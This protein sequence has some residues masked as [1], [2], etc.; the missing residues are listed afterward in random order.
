MTEVTKP[1]VFLDVD[2][3][4]NCFET[5]EE[6]YVQD[7][8]FVPTA[9]RPFLIRIREN[10]AEWL[11]ELPE[12]ADVYW[13]TT[14]CE[15]ANTCLAP[16]FDLPTFPVAGEKTC[17]EDDEWKTAWKFDMLWET[18]SKDPRPF[19]WIDDEA[20]GETWYREAHDF[21]LFGDTPHLLVE[22]DGDCALTDTQL[23]E[24]N[25]FLRSHA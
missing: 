10:V 1:Y 8:V 4:L 19:V 24:I 11:H 17:L 15:E 5:P 3:V 23:I 20:I 13:N 25:T 22:P 18:W 6:R 21:S 12:L 16:A 7:S 9:R 2:G 14:W